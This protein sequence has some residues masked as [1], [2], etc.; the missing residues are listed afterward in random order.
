MTRIE[1][2][3]SIGPALRNGRRDGNSVVVDV[4][5]LAGHNNPTGEPARA[6]E[7]LVF[8]RDE[9]GGQVAEKRHWI[10]RRIELPE[11][12]EVSDNTLLPGETREV[13]FSF[14]ESEVDAAQGAVVEAS[15]HRLH[16]LSA[17]AAAG[18]LLDRQ[19][20]AIVDLS[21]SW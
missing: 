17:A 13:R 19:R 20:V 3:C 7:I 6:L 15:L 18:E 5:N 16:N 1:E 10:M 2:P 21:V 11:M 12:R 9:L 4:V 8:L 14:A